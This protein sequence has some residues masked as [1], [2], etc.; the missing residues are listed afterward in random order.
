MEFVFATGNLHKLQEA[1]E[2]LGTEVVLK[3]LQDL[4]FSGDIPE[5]QPTIEGNAIQKAQFIYDRFG[6]DCFADDTGLEIDALNG[7]P[8]VYSARYAGEG[9]SFQDNVDKVLRELEGCENRSARFRCVIALIAKGEVHTFEGVVEGKILTA[10][11]GEKGFGYDPVFQPE[12]SDLS[13]AQMSAD[14]KHA[15]SHRGRALEKFHRFLL[16]L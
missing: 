8:G 11:T 3:S 9:C 6:E 7:R 13:F 16:N 10:P 2:I 15:I 5:E 4:G 12:E 1:R 14:Q